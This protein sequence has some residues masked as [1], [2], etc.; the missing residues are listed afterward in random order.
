MKI[1]STVK[2]ITLVTHDLH[3]RIYIT[4]GG[5]YDATC[6]LFTAQVASKKR[7]FSVHH[8]LACSVLGPLWNDRLWLFHSGEMFILCWMRILLKFLKSFEHTRKTLKL[9]ID[10]RHIFTRYLH[11]RKMF[12]NSTPGIQCHPSFTP[13]P[14]KSIIRIFPKVLSGNSEHCQVPPELWEPSLDRNVS[15]LPCNLPESPLLSLNFS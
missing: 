14:S 1:R 11:I 5:W 15:D 6:L 7:I 10:W 8:L 12:E 13:P 4:V 3:H 9:L 2:H